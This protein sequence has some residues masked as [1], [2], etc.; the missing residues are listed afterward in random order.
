MVRKTLKV[1]FL[2]SGKIAI[3]LLIKA[4]RSEYLD[5]VLVSSRNLESDGLKKCS[6]LGVDISDKGLQGILELNEPVD[7]I[8]DCTSAMAHIKHWELIKKTDIKV[9]DMTP[10]GIGLSIV[11]VVNSDEIL[12]HQNV[13][14][15]SCGGQASIPLIYAVAKAQKG[16]SY[17]EIVSS[18][19]S[20]S[21]GPATRA[22]IDEYIELTEDAARIFSDTN[23][24]KVILI[25]NP[26][27][28]PI[29]MQ[30]SIS[31]LTEGVNINLN[32]V[33]ES[34]HLMVEKIKAYVPGYELLVEPVIVG[35]K[36]LIGMV[37]VVG[38][39]DFL[40]SYAGN[41]DII[42]CAAIS[43]AEN[44]SIRK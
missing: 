35:D 20:K 9:I 1:A 26:A 44:F 13:N 32:A 27:E 6:S 21:A 4:K 8:F 22:N 41:L 38:L 34:V 33:K 15:I 39:G 3:D 25:L 37:K 24:A 10:S 31:F 29:S 12:M 40:P 17:V 43:V 16:L 14:M 30:T 5:C 11:P 7:L 28:P 2:G 23:D 19:A 36:R 18:I 42:N